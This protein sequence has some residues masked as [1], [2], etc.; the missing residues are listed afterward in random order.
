MNAV[1]APSGKRSLEE[2]V[3]QTD[4]TSSP[5]KKRRIDSSATKVAAKPFLREIT[6]KVPWFT[7]SKMQI[8]AAYSRSA[9]ND[10][11]FLKTVGALSDEKYT[12]WVLA[13]KFV[14]AADL[15]LDRHHVLGGN[16]KHRIPE[17]MRFFFVDHQRNLCA[18]IDD[19]PSDLDIDVVQHC[20]A[21]ET[22]VVRQ[23]RQRSGDYDGSD[24]DDSDDGDISSDQRAGK[25]AESKIV[26]IV[27]IPMFYYHQNLKSS[28]YAVCCRAAKYLQKRRHYGHPLFS[29]L[30]KNIANFDSFQQ[31]LPMV[32]LRGSLY[33]MFCR[34]GLG[35]F[36]RGDSITKHHVV[37]RSGFET[38]LGLF[39]CWREM[40][41]REECR[42]VMYQHWAEST[43][44][45]TNIM[46]VVVEMAGL[47]QMDDAKVL[48]WA[49]TLKITKYTD[50]KKELRARIANL[51]EV[52]DFNSV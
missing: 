49:D 1:S 19:G 27:R 15:R 50:Y 22:S 3:D 23:Y 12:R 42:K 33:E 11:L 51:K 38:F 21:I 24:S 14:I 4:V 36:H 17:N 29:I 8:N 30:F 9:A 20:R 13:C 39:D 37:N 31:S 10:D 35:G 26:H 46:R 5:P 25:E 45:D 34:F 32:P 44:T 7:D 2:Y 28:F 52:V 48:E 41:R 18:V 16:D 40:E 43:G 6:C 47:E